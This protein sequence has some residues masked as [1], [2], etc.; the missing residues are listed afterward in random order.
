MKDAE[1]ESYVSAIERH[2]GRRRGREHVLAPPEFEL[3]RQWFTAGV[4][5]STVLTGIDDAFSTDAV[6][7]SL[8][9]CRR[10]VE[11]LTHPGRRG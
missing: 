7:T 6:P 4:S 11:A 1:L 5:L 2:L 8:T 9:S 10:F 3:T